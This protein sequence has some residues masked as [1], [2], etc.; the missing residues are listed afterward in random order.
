MVTLNGLFLAN[1]QI[2]IR[3]YVTMCV[4]WMYVRKYEC[5]L[6]NEWMSECVCVPVCLHLHVS[7]CMCVCVL[8]QLSAPHIELHM[9]SG[10]INWFTT[11]LQQVHCTVKGIKFILIL[12][13]GI[14]AI[15]A[16]RW[17]WEMECYNCNCLLPEALSMGISSEGIRRSERI[18]RRRRNTSRSRGD[19]AKDFWYMD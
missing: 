18:G 4:C 9:Y 13:F 12:A 16:W 14:C 6:V 2:H 7:V 5:E 17:D 1:S 3:I 11:C 8:L 15:F 19:L 10:F